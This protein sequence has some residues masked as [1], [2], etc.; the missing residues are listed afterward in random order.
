MKKNH[1]KGKMVEPQEKSV[2]EDD[3]PP[4]PL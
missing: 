3:K 1:Q 2:V 4:A